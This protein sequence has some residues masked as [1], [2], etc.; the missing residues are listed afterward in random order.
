[1]NQEA[2]KLLMMFIK[3]IYKNKNGN[4]SKKTALSAMTYVSHNPELSRYVNDS[5]WIKVVN[6]SQATQDNL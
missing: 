2:E 3:D 6:Y 4:P 5:D 1:M